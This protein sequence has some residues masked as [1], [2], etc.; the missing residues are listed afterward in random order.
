MTS[1]QNDNKMKEKKRN[2]K[3][4][5]S[6]LIEMMRV[7]R[8]PPPPSRRRLRSNNSEKREFVE[9]IFECYDTTTTRWRWWWLRGDERR[10]GND[11]MMS[12]AEKHI[13]AGSIETMYSLSLMRNITE[14]IWPTSFDRW[15]FADSYFGRPIVK[16]TIFYR[17]VI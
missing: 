10:A 7:W 16:P 17:R 6:I 4:N 3:I 13:T 15:S 14:Y 12:A 8:T 1:R 5:K 11:M 2:N 9:T